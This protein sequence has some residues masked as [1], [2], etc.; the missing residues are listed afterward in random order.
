M[1]VG[2]RRRVDRL[3]PA[4]GF[5]AFHEQA[6]PYPRPPGA[7]CHGPSHQ[8]PGPAP[9]RAT[10]GSTH[11]IQPRPNPAHFKLLLGRL[12][13]KRATPESLQALRSR[14]FP[15]RPSIT[16]ASATQP[17]STPAFLQAP[18]PSP[19]PASSARLSALVLPLPSVPASSH[20]CWGVH[21]LQ[22]LL[23][24]STVPFPALVQLPRRLP[25][26]ACLWKE[27]REDPPHDRPPPSQAA[28]FVWAK[29]TL[30]GLEEAALFCPGVLGGLETSSKSSGVPRPGSWG[31]GWG[32]G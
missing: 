9:S 1:G 3:D 12:P 24:L 32:Q 6:L 30:R 13:L 11:Q 5:S 19:S 20:T 29:N 2:A 26:R 23:A 10:L 28:R 16:Q 8:A 27:R 25:H 14:C 18:P 21:G 31:W 15:P 7:V 22:R 4:Q 17:T